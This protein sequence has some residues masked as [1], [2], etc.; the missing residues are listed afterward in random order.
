MGPGAIREEVG[1]LR[2]RGGTGRFLSEGAGNITSCSGG[3]R[4]GF[5]KEA[6][7]SRLLLI[8]GEKKGGGSSQ[9]LGQVALFRANRR[10]P[11]ALKENLRY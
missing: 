2:S 10:M 6:G 5:L 8:W 3:K 11:Q 1:F 7:R 4:E 9:S